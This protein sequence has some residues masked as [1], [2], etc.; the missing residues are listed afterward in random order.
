[1]VIL[2]QC[3][4]IPNACIVHRRGPRSIIG[5]DI[6]FHGKCQRCIWPHDF[7][8]PVLRWLKWW[9]LTYMHMYIYIYIMYTTACL[10]A[11]SSTIKCAYS[12]FIGPVN[13]YSME[14]YY[15]TLNHWY[16]KPV[17]TTINQINAYYL[18]CSHLKK[19]CV[20]AERSSKSEYAP[21]N[22]PCVTITENKWFYIPNT[23]ICGKYQRCVRYILL[24]IETWLVQYTRH[25][26]NQR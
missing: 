8:S 1:M 26:L 25:I 9:K 16:I 23:F 5:G 12:L 14:L 22:Q 18:E 4:V 20:E 2:L 15:I 17:I 13:T 21:C 10:F 6:W 19:Q 24:V 3:Q 7:I 11:N